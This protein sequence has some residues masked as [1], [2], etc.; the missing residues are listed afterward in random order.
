MLKSPYYDVW[1]SFKD[2]HRLI[3]KPDLC[4]L[5]QIKIH[6]YKC[7]DQSERMKKYSKYSDQQRFNKYTV[8]AAVQQKYHYA[9]CR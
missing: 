3:V 4:K 1:S 9:L 5:M 2:V 7:S 8:V 6:Y